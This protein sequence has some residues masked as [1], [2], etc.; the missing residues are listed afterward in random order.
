MT[1]ESNINPEK[2]EES[3]T[4]LHD[5]WKTFPIKKTKGL[6]NGSEYFSQGKNTTTD[7]RQPTPTTIA[8][9]E[10]EI[11]MMTNADEERIQKASE[12]DAMIQSIR[13]ASMSVID[14][15]DDLAEGLTPLEDV[16]SAHVRPPGHPNAGTDAH[17]VEL[18]VYTMNIMGVC[19]PTRSAHYICLALACR[20]R[21]LLSILA[22]LTLSV[23]IIQ[24]YM[25]NATTRC[26]SGTLGSAVLRAHH[27]SGVIAWDIMAQPAAV[28]G[29][30]LS[31]TH[32][33]NDKGQC[34]G[35]AAQASMQ[36]PRSKRVVIGT[37]SELHL[38]WESRVQTALI[39]SAFIS[40]SCTIGIDL[41]LCP[42]W[43]RHI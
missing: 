42:K 23:L 41:S 21:I 3:R 18:I 38:L 27:I 25:R 15:H 5:D 26:I 33:L 31:R 11:T 4:P 30:D 22:T 35:Q 20:P 14:T 32:R 1:Y 40:L 34:I 36:L 12:N 2:S 7:Q 16:G 9:Q 39:L 29:V 24:T 37:A 13:K 19:I 28:M 43:I 10:M 6:V 8:T 17:W